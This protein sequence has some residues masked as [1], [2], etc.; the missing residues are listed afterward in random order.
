MSQDTCC[1]LQYANQDE[2]V[3]LLFD[4]WCKLSVLKAENDICRLKV[5]ECVVAL[6]NKVDRILY[7]LY[8]LR[9]Y[10]QLHASVI[11]SILWL[12]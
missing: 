12:N 1:I 9:I 10:N 3:Q 6:I 4:S 7:V 11:F 5:A 2:K 8:T